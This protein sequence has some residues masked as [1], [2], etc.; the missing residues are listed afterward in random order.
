MN[1]KLLLNW[2]WGGKYFVASF[3]YVLVKHALL[4]Q[5][6]FHLS[7]SKCFQ[8]SFINR[9]QK[10]SKYSKL[11]WGLYSGSGTVT[12]PPSKNEWDEHENG[13]KH[14]KYLFQKKIF[15]VNSGYGFLFGS[16]GHFI[17]KCGKYFYKIRQAFNYK[18]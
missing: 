1:W 18:M 13:I 12:H 11:L 17:T 9:V 4:P 16:L 5:I 6:C 15:L 8:G 10:S 14:K 7:V 3:K 2:L